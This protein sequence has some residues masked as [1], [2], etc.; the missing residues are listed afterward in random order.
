[1]VF[2]FEA[3][4]TPSSCSTSQAYAPESLVSAA[5]I[6]NVLLMLLTTCAPF[7]NQRYWTN[8][9]AGGRVLQVMLTVSPLVKV[10]LPAVMMYGIP[11]LL[12][13][14]INDSLK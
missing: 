11:Y 5:E 2:V 9:P 4:L 8:K 13:V 10:L 1:M 6:T 3:I 12:T 7:L 14:T